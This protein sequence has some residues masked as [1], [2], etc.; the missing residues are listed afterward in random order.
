MER[1]RS[2]GGPKRARRLGA[3]YRAL[4]AN[5]LPWNVCWLKRGTICLPLPR[6]L[7]LNVIPQHIFRFP[8]TKLTVTHRRLRNRARPVAYYGNFNHPPRETS[9]TCVSIDPRWM[10][11]FVTCAHRRRAPLFYLFIYRVY[12][13]ARVRFG[14]IVERGAIV[15][16]LFHRDRTWSYNYCN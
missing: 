9:P 11:I 10:P 5:I 2:G 16:S 8:S 15:A 6:D 1:R 14:L 12:V 4:A 13:C 3:F 7:L